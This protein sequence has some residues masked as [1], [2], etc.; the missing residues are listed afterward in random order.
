M[1]SDNT[2]AASQSTVSQSSSTQFAAVRGR[3]F[4]NAAQAAEYLGGLNPRTLIRWA[5]EGY[6]PAYPIGEGKRRLWRFVA[7]DLDQW[8]LARRTGCPNVPLSTV[9]RTLYASHRCSDRRNN[10]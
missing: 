8:M 1:L 6:L 5:R 3:R 4:L 7:E 2:D 10:Q 9:S